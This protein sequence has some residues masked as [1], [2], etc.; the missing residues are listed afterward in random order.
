MIQVTVICA[1][2]SVQLFVHVSF[3]HDDISKCY[4]VSR[5]FSDIVWSFIPLGVH[6]PALLMRSLDNCLFL[7]PEHWTLLVW[8]ST[9]SNLD[10]KRTSDWCAVAVSLLLI[11]AWVTN[12][13]LRLSRM[14]WRHYN[15]RQVHRSTSAFFRRHRCCHRR[16]RHHHHHHHHLT[17]PPVILPKP[18]LITVMTS[19][20]TWPSKK[21]LDVIW[22]LTNSHYSVVWLVLLLLSVSSID[23]VGDQN[24]PHW[25]H[26]IIHSGDKPCEQIVA[27]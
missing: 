7:E 10:A 25:L 20:I 6:C 12:K 23:V 8:S 17:L 1:N 4:R 22:R 18:T 3:M 14:R 19:P 2:I 24:I 27:L 11:Q 5:G 26:C 9:N 13:Q 21:V 16:R 15:T